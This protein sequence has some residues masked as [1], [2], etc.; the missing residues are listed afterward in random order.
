MAT[1]YGTINTSEGPVNPDDKTAEIKEK[2]PPE[3]VTE[4]IIE[5]EG[6]E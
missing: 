3:E 6:D 4:I 5:V 2:F 1:P